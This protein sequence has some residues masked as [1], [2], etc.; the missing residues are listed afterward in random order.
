MVNPASA[1]SASRNRARPYL[2]LLALPFIWQL[3]LAP[4]VNEISIS[5]LGLPF[6]LLWQM[7]GILFTSLI[8]IIVYRRDRRGQRT[9]EPSGN[10]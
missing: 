6:P 9:E 1:R 3:A 7:I 8:L 10:S 5:P 4:Y 2:A